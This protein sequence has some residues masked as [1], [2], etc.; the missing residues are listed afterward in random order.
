M[1]P[2]TSKPSLDTLRTVMARSPANRQ[3]IGVANTTQ[4]LAHLAHT[5]CCRR[6]RAAINRDL[7]ITVAIT[8]AVPRSPSRTSRHLSPSE[9]TTGTRKPTASCDVVGA[10]AYAQHIDLSQPSRPRHLRRLPCRTSFRCCANGEMQNT[11]TSLFLAQCCFRTP[12]KP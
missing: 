8:V 10:R 5:Q 1:L 6:R 3:A 9:W 4:C 7:A 12:T 2:H 11:D